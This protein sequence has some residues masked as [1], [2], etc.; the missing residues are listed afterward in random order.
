MCILHRLRKKRVGHIP[1]ERH[2]YESDD[3]VCVC[4]CA[5][6]FVCLCVCVCLYLRVC[7]CICV[8]VRA[9]VICARVRARACVLLLLFQRVLFSIGGSFLYYANHFK[10]YSSFCAS[11]SRTQKILNP[12]KSTVSGHL[13]GI[14][15]SICKTVG[16]LACR[17]CWVTPFSTIEVYIYCS[18]M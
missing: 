17:V 9:C 12:G 13:T 1:S 8:C 7:V 4:V 16:C 14:R 2:F 18:A 5:F 10:V 11:H 15:Q 3:C 6:V